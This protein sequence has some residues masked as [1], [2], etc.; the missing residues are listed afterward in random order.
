M[1]KIFCLFL[2]FI[3]STLYTQ[4]LDSL[5]VALKNAKHDSTRV[6]ILSEL[7][8]YCEVVDIL[9]FSEP[10][11]KIARKNISVSKTKSIKNYYLKYLSR[12]LNNVAYISHKN[13]DIKKALNSYEESLIIL[14]ELQDKS[15][16]ANTLNNIGFIYK[17]QG[18]IQKSLKYH[19]KSLALQLQVNDKLGM[20]Y[21]LNEIGMLYES[22]GDIP[23]AL[24]YFHKSLKINEEINNQIGIG[25]AL[26]NIGNVFE[27]QADHGKALEYLKK[28][29]KISEKINNKSKIANNLLNIGSIYKSQGDINNSLDCYNNSLKIAEQIQDKG[30]IAYALHNIGDVFV[31]KGDNKNALT[32]FKRSLKIRE[33]IDD[34]QGISNTLANLANVILIEGKLMEAQN[35][36]MSSLK[37]AKEIGFPENIKNAATTLKAIY[38]SQ[39]KYKNAFEMYSLE[40]LMRDSINNQKTQKA[41]IKKQ[42]Q[43]T[44]EKKELEIKAEQDKKDIITIKEKQKQKIITYSVSFGF[45]IVLVLGLFILRGFKQKQKAN[46][47]ITKQKL[48]VENQKHLIEEKHKEITDSINYAERIQRSFL[49]TSTLLDENLND[50]FVYFQPKDVVSGDFY[51]AH[52]LTDGKF[53]LVTADSTGHGVPGAIMSLLN[54]TSLESAIKDG[55]N[56]PAEIFNHTRQTIIERLKLDGSIEGGKDGMDGS[57]ICFDFKNNKFTYTAANNPIWIVRQNELIELKGDKMPVGKHDKDQVLFTQHEFELNKGDV[58]YAITDGF[59]DQFGGTKGKKFMYKQLK[60]ILVSISAK[61]LSEQKETLNTILKEWMGDVEQVDDITIIGVRI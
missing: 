53:A 56:E 13:G 25:D 24:E 47:I 12:A 60:E 35:Y 42:M 6:K 54:V 2:I 40:I 32:Y 43:Y 36:A 7:S 27:N 17:V 48:E 50:Y 38:Q 18:H 59:P 15:G 34:K 58:I 45:I 28:A 33:D 46:L 57:L 23:K 44:Y 26:N 20:A 5:K 14:Q 31:K 49:A 22:Q 41:S 21:T 3:Y 8:E 11:V 16:I 51:W 39:N 1:K 10:C 19:N 61:P 4:N 30:L 52:K 9:K 55:H 37:I 29:L